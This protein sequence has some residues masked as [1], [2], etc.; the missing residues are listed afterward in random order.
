L[1]VFGWGFVLNYSPHYTSGQQRQHLNKRLNLSTKRQT[2]IG[3]VEQ[4]KTL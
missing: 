2:A 1:F 3:S 4:K